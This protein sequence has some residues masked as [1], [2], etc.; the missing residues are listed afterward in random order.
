[1]DS[2]ILQNDVSIDNTIE[3]D[4]LLEKHEKIDEAG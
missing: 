3:V 2:D 1:M 4:H